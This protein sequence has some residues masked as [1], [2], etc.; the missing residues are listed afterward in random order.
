[1][2]WNPLRRTRIKPKAKQHRESAPWRQQRIRLDAKGMWALRSEVFA[3]AQFQCEN[4]IYG[5]RCP[6]KIG[7]HSFQLHHI[8]H[9]SQGGSDSAENTLALCWDCHEDHHRGRRKVEIRQA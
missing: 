6:A 2:N 4:L 3:R 7:W 9:R 1:M 8:I 5:E